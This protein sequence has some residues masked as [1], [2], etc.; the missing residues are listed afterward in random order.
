M[1][2]FRTFRR[3][4]HVWDAGDVLKRVYTCLARVRNA[5]VLDLHVIWREC[6]Q[7]IRVIKTILSTLT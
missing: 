7:I 5:L 4:R 1:S 6:L 3:G 2:M